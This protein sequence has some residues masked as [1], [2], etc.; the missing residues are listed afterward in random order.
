MSSTATPPRPHLKLLFDE[1][2]DGRPETG[3]GGPPSPRFGQHLTLP[4]LLICPVQA[5]GAIAQITFHEA[6]LSTKGLTEGYQNVD[7]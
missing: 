5:V 7:V 4:Q 3:V 6:F 1:Q 2:V